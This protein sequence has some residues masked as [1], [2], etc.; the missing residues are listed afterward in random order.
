MCLQVKVGEALT[1]SKS[2]FLEAKLAKTP[3]S[4]TME[5]VRASFSLRRLKRSSYAG[6][7]RN[8]NGMV[9]QKPSLKKYRKMKDIQSKLT[10][11]LTLYVCIY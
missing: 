8:R 4:M 9:V 6:Q 3:S 7:S 5:L 1:L 10:N 11:T 2:V